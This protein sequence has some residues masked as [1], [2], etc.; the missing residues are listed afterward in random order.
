MVDF[1]NIFKNKVSVEE[2]PDNEKSGETIYSATFDK[3]KQ[4]VGALNMVGAGFEAKGGSTLMLTESVENGVDA[5]IK[6]NEKRKIKIEGEIK[7]I[8][9]Q[10]NKRIL[11]VDNGTGFIQIKHICEKPFD[12]LKEMDVTQTGKFA[13]GLQGF[14]AFCENLSYVTKRLPED[15]PSI[16][17]EG[18]NGSKETARLEFVSIS[19][20]VKV[21]YVDNSD[22]IEYS[23]S[24]HGTIAI[25]ENWKPGLFDKF[26]INVLFKRLQHHFG[27]LIRKG[28]ISIVVELRPGKIAGIGPEQLKFQE[29]EPRDYSLFT[30]LA[31]ESIKYS[32]GEKKGAINF[33]L[34]LC[35]RGKKDR[36]NAPYLLFQNRPVGDGF[37]WGI[38]EFAEHPIWEHR[39]LTGYIT[40]DFC[41]INE[42]RQGLKINEERDFLFKE[43][44]KI[45]KS[46]ENKIK[47]HS[48]G[49]YELKLQKQVNELVQDL[50]L[51]F[52][53]KHIFNFK[54]AR[55]TGFLSKEN[56][57]IEIVELANAQGPNP[58]LEVKNDKGDETVILDMDKFD[59]VDVKPQDG[60]TEK[61]LN[62]EIGVHGKGSSESK[63]GSAGLEATKNVEP[64]DETEKGFEKSED[65]V[66]KPVE[67]I[68]PHES[69]GKDKQKKKGTRHKPRGFG[70]VFQ[71]DEFNEDL[72][73][74]DEVNSVVIINSQH[75]RFLSRSQD[76]SQF[77]SL[78]GYLAELYIWEITKLVHSKDEELPK[79]MKFLDYKFE[80]F[81]NMRKDEKEGRY[82]NESEPESE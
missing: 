72:S 28:D 42:L 40:C 58:N 37:I 30:P 10:V 2:M 71:D 20:K 68:E 35:D 46:L 66:T 69:G 50:Q 67:S 16:E 52:K 43:L 65:N 23:D 76:E 81:E 39:F 29:V 19:S 63:V 44:I 54:L 47:E 34:Y 57:E 45:E 56:D 8:I 75:P 17:H 80:Y 3:E 41:E 77:K 27:E 7:V 79:T 21:K 53:S 60:G 9:D 78:M 4:I 25:Y 24:E 22:F 31:V 82:L 74:F 61:T 32:N 5:I 48:K 59:E 73:W 15:I 38:D 11:V 70:L 55:S 64:D 13:R 18:S 12:S 6:F 26:N 62:P 49:L 1:K 36:W 14:R 51:F 33:V